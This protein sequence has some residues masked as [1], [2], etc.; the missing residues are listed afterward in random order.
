MRLDDVNAFV[1]AK[2]VYDRAQRNLFGDAERTVYLDTATQ[3]RE[4]A[5]ATDSSIK[6]VSAADSSFPILQFTYR[7]VDFCYVGGKEDDR[8]AFPF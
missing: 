6:R 2:R 5:T 3:F 7:G 8:W 1:D 4:C